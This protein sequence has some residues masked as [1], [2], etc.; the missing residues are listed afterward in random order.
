M[1]TV[2]PHVRLQN[3]ELKAKNQELEA[4]VCGFVCVCVKQGYSAKGTTTRGRSML[5]C[6]A[7][8]GFWAC[9]RHAGPYGAHKPLIAFACPALSSCGSLLP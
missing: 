1:E 6:D 5:G 3:E 8:R 7:H 4:K 2:S 9:L